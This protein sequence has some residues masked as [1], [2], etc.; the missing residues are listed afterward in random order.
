M[1][2][3][4]GSRLNFKGK[5]I[6]L[7]NAFHES[8]PG[9]PSNPNASAPPSDDILSSADASL[10]KDA[11]KELDPN[12][13]AFPQSKNQLIP[14]GSDSEEIEEE[15]GMTVSGRKASMALVALGRAARSFLLYEPDNQAVT[16][17][18][19]DLRD[20]FY[21]FL[22]QYG[23]MVLD[24]RPWEMMMGSEVVYLNRDRERSL[25]FRLFRDGVR[26]VTITPDVQW[27]E[28]TKFLGIISIRYTG[29]RQQ[30]DDIVVMLWKAG[31]KHIVVESV[32]GFVPEDDDVDVDTTIYSDDD[33]ADSALTLYAAAPDGF[34]IPWPVYNERASIRYVEMDSEHLRKLDE[35]VSNLTLPAQCVGL[36]KEILETAANPVEPMKLEEAI[37]MVQEV[38]NFLSA[39]GLLSSLLEVMR[40]V[41]ALPF[42]QRDEEHRDELLRAFSD[43]NVL[44]RVI[45]SFPAGLQEVPPQLIEL[46]EMV[47]EDPVPMLLEILNN[48]RTRTARLVTRNLLVRMGSDKLDHLVKA[49]DQLKA[50]VAADLLRVVSDIDLDRGIRMGIDMG[51]EADVDL[52]LVALSL[53]ERGPYSKRVSRY[54]INLLESSSMEVRMHALKLLVLNKEPSAFSNIT[55]R[56]EHNAAGNEMDLHEVEALGSAMVTIREDRALEQFVEWIQPKKLLQRMLPR[57]QNLKWAAVTGLSQIPGD[58]AKKYIRL[59][60]KTAGEELHRHCMKSLVLQRR[61]GMEVP[62]G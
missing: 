50:P 20:K 16:S 53:M 13:A 26:K 52:Q 46:V 37:P 9:T 61:L 43:V 28:L 11:R 41:Q 4:D 23:E 42:N 62:D 22:D 33:T 56:L 59:A 24:V 29:I 25:S 39:E 1:T 2:N 55:R 47:P 58:Q 7:K 34:D 10:R 15:V 44:V 30:E 45:R 19:Q 51:I 32:E 60:A 27:N 3:G 6:P 35:E 54:L 17:F 57:R 36:L 40:I 49:I 48:E 8:D 5:K 18:L 21:G 14:S 12:G 31:F 38:A